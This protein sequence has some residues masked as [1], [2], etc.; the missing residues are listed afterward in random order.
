M[1]EW[2]TY[3]KLNIQ[4]EEALNRF[5]WMCEGPALSWYVSAKKMVCV[6]TSLRLQ[7]YFTK[8]CVARIALHYLA[9]LSALSLTTPALT[10]LLPALL[11]V[12]RLFANASPPSLSFT[13]LLSWNILSLC[14]CIPIVL[15]IS[16]TTCLFLV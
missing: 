5:S 8:L 4:K 3:Q 15:P 6:V 2:L 14:P 12:A 13:I 9:S 11:D 16:L 10:D 1:A 7:W